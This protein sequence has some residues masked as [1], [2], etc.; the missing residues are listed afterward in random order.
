MIHAGADARVIT[1]PLDDPLRPVFL[2]GFQTD[3]RATGVHQDLHVRTL[4]LRED[5]G[6]TFVLCVCDLI[7]VLREDSLAI[8]ASV[9]D[10]AADVVVAATHTH[11]GPDTIGLW[12]PDDVTRGVDEAYLREMRAVAAASIRAA[13]AALEPALLR[14][15]VTEVGGVIRNL[16]DP[17][18]LDEQLAVLAV[19]RPDATALAT[20]ANVPIHPEVLDGDSTLVGPDMAGACARA[21]EVARGG[22]GI[23]V[24]AGLGGMQ[25]PAE[26]PRTPEEAERKGALCAAAALSALI[27]AAPAEDAHVRYRGTEVALPLHN[28]RFREA[29]ERGIVRADL[30]PDG[31]L[32]TDIGVLDLGPAR[33]ACWPG[34][35]LPA[36][37][38]ASKDRLGVAYPFLFGL[39]NDE[40][41][42]FVPPEAWVEPEGAPDP[43]VHY[44]ERMSLGPETAPRIEAAL[45][46][47]LEEL[48]TA[49]TPG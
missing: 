11:S 5:H 48:V 37:G 35:A 16:R 40:I 31:S 28:R 25:S 15:A 8:R 1:P 6:P 26:G 34:E 47:L 18:I 42:Y 10:L 20:L 29:L 39:A 32:V 44:E 19:D 43:D 45:A 9:A 17:E 7:G 12:G 14:F 49:S 38:I 27:S 33:A 21:L 46:S 4:A 41:G 23:W 13:V 2:A 30:R 22:V 3:R 36:V 24:S